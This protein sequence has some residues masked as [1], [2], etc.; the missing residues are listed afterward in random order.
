[1]KYLSSIPNKEGFEFIAVLKNGGTVKTKVI[2][3]EKGLHS[4]PEFSN[5]IGWLDLKLIMNH[6]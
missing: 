3:D 6:E 2:K 4:F 1:M 5:S